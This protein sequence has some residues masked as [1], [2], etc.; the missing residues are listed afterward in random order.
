MPSR[1]TIPFRGKNSAQ[2][3]DTDAQALFTAMETDGSP[4]TLSDSVKGYWNTYVL[5]MKADGLWTDVI[6]LY[7]F[8]AGTAAC[9]KYNAKNT[10]TYSLTYYNSPTHSANG[11]VGNGSTMSIDTG[12][13][14][15]TVNE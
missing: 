14:N 5:G 9:N 1:I 3:Y 7:P 12:I 11:V 8:L 6:G 2:G 10:A 15:S 13:P 4:V